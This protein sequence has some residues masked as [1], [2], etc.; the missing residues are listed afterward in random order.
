MAGRLLFVILMYFFA[1]I[2][3]QALLPP[4]L[5]VNPAVITETD[6]VILNCQT[7]SSVSVSQCYFRTDRG[8]PAKGF[9]CLKTLTGTELLK[10]TKQSSPAEVKVTCFYLHVSPSPDSDMSSIT[11]HTLPPKLT[12]TQRVITDADSVIL[13]CQ[14]PSS[15]SGSQCYFYTEGGG[16][17]KS[18]SC[19]Q[20]L[21]ATE[22]LL[23]ARQSSPAEV[24]VKCYYL[25]TYPSLHSDTS[26]IIIQT[27][28]LPTLTVNPAVITE[29]DSVTL[30]CQTPSS[31][32]VSQC[33][34]YTVGQ[35]SPTI[36]SCMKTLTGSELLNMAHQSSPSE[37]KVKCFYTVKLGDLNSPSPHSDTSSITIHNIMERESRMPPTM[38]TFSMS[39]GQKPEITFQHFYG[40]RVFFTCSL[41]GSAN[42]DTRCNLYLGEATRPVLTTNTERKKTSTNQ[43]FCQFTV[44]INDLLRRLHL[45]QQS[46]AS[47]D[48]SL[49]SEPNSLSPR[50]DR[51]KLTE[52]VERESYMTPTMPTF[53]MTTG[54]TVNNPGAS[55]PV[56][57]VKT[58]SSQ[59]IG[60][61]SDTGASI[62][63]FLTSVKPEAVT[64]I[65]SSA[66][67]S[68]T[69]ADTTSINPTCGDEITG[70]LT[71]MTRAGVSVG[72]V[73]LGLALLFTKSRTDNCVFN[74]P[75]AKVAGLPH[76]YDETYSIIL[77][78]CNTEKC[79]SK[80]QKTNVTGLPDGYDETYSIVTYECDT[81]MTAAPQR[82]LIHQP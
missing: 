44:I 45:G 26:S 34:F 27:S 59:T 81:V 43:R 73:L 6:S 78:E 41:P 5:T 69:S 57:L 14:T 46:D 76:G 74:R 54:L 68:L 4:K 52:I 72:V 19:L 8:G 61:P 33:Y 63:T 62:S 15:L 29:T 16:P 60:T 42:R 24:K 50:S 66:A 13:N 28:Q 12:V 3:A 51:Y 48:Y 37:V 77:Y 32:S 23:M 70:K 79:S 36:L 40:D 21:L 31:V 20:T 2:Q 82:S 18:F 47:C 58:T 55:T 64:G 17:P 9:S 56:T 1:E 53:S 7:P 30:N 71:L 80:R 38:P 35:D 49:G 65:T 22:L 75:K 67:G 25:T 10:M 11:I 39:T